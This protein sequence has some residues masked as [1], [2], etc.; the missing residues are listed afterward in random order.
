MNDTPATV[1]L[2]E[3]DPADAGVIQAAL[4]GADEGSFRVE[5]VTRLPDA[6][7]L[8]A[9]EGIDVALLDGMSAEDFRRLLVTGKDEPS[10]RRPG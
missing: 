2:V 9:R 10:E 8:V 5:W 3:G 1:L 4:T 6:L 7:E